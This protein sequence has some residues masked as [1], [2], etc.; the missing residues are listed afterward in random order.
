[1]SADPSPTDFTTTG[2]IPVEPFLEAPITRS[3]TAPDHSNLD[4]G[5]CVGRFRSRGEDPLDPMPFEVSGQ[6]FAVAESLRPTVGLSWRPT[7]LPIRAFR[8]AQVIG[9][10]VLS[11]LAAL[12]VMLTMGSGPGHQR[13]SGP[14]KLMTESESETGKSKAA[15]PQAVEPTHTGADSGTDTDPFG[16]TDS[17]VTADGKAATDSTVVTATYPEDDTDVVQPRQQP[18]RPKA[19]DE[20]ESPATS[21]QPEPS[22]VLSIPTVDRA[23]ARDI[24]VDT[25]GSTRQTPKTVPTTE[26]DLDDRADSE[27]NRDLTD[28][29]SLT[30]VETR[31]PKPIPTPAPGKSENTD[32]EP[33]PP[34]S[35]PVPTEL[36]PIT[37]EP[38]QVESENN[39]IGASNVLDTEAV[40]GEAPD[41]QD[42]DAEDLDDGDDYRQEAEGD[43][44]TIEITEAPEVAATV[45][46]T[47]LPPGQR[48]KQGNKSGVAADRS[49]RT[50]TKATP[51]GLTSKARGPRLNKSKAKPQR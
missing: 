43:E 14:I 45:V 26:P 48:K 1:M 9:L 46:D 33:I 6:G 17:N 41:S 23:P 51:A 12:I 20:P 15:S 19:L 5:A 35:I 2:E 47:N 18:L 49:A 50:K 13:S 27:L 42:L 10:V 16:T 25:S 11:A 37:P 32:T 21:K 34:K 31:N 28:D 29:I 44:S 24:K 3:L 30:T 22:D 7:D 40:A 8:V 36:G 4:P 38:A 39:E